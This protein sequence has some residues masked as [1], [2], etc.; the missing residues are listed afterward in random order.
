MLNPFNI[1]ILIIALCPIGLNAKDKLT[2]SYPI[3]VVEVKDGDTLKVM[4]HHW[5]DTWLT[6]SVRVYGIDTPEKH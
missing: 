2:N 1:L 6:T 5:L 3:V 4:A